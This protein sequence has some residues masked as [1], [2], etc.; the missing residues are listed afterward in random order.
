MGMST[1]RERRARRWVWGC[2]GGCLGCIVILLVGIYLG[3]RH[4]MQPVVVVPPQTFLTRDTSA[5]LFVRVDPQV[6]LMMETAADVILRP[7]V[8][9]VIPIKPGE[10]IDLDREKS[11]DYLSSFAPVQAVLALQPEKEADVI[12]GGLAVSVRSGSRLLSALVKQGIKAPVT[13]HEYK[14]AEIAALSENAYVALRE[15]NYMSSDREELLKAWA[16]NLMLERQ[17]EEQAAQG[18]HPPAPALIIS[19]ALKRPYDRLDSSLPIVFA[20][21]NTRHELASLTALISNEDARRLIEYTGIVSDGVLSLAGQV[22]PLSPRDAE[23]TLFIDCADADLAGRM[24]DRLEGAAGGSGGDV[25]PLKDT[26][27]AVQDGTVLKVTGRINDL[28]A[29]VADIVAAVIRRAGQAPA[30]APQ[31]PPE[32]EAPQEP[33]APPEPAPSVST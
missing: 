7:E 14:G 25:W 9:G 15:N 24:R 1:E 10:Q 27:V 31:P 33:P 3:V 26:A 17:R 11:V 13:F 30:E 4:F 28:P 6:P 5:F 32:P 23:L 8:I 20:S 12:H 2:T 22:R 29:K 19:P 21:L 16:G 18:G